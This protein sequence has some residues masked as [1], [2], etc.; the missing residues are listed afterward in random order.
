[1]KLHLKP[2]LLAAAIAL[3][4]F[5]SSCSSVGGLFDD[6]GHRYYSPDHRPVDIYEN[7][8]AATSSENRQAGRSYSIT[9]QQGRT[10]QTTAEEEAQENA[11]TA[12]PGTAPVLA[13]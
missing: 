13:E 12:V 5:L 8:R 3:P 7:D 9:N 10:H 1:M 11:E 6:S 4:V 2:S